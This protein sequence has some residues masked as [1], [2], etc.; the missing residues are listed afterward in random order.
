MIR[1][2]SVE[3]MIS[4]ENAIKNLGVTEE[5][6]VMRAGGAIAEEILSRFKGGRILFVC[7]KGNNGADGKVASA[8][9][10]QKHGFKVGVCEVD[11]NLSAF[12]KEWDV[13]VDCIFGTGLNR[14]VTG[15]PLKVIKAINNA[16]GYKIAVDLPSG[17]GGN[18]GVILGA[19][20]KADLTIAIQEYKLGHFFG[21]GVENSGELV[22]KDIGISVWGDDYA[23]LTE[24]S[25]ALQCFPKR[26]K[27]TS[28]GSYGRA[29]VIGGSKRFCGAPLLA[30]SACLKTGVGYTTLAVPDC[31]F[32]AVAGKN[33]E[34][35]VYTL[36][37][38]N[39]AVKFSEDEI[40]PL[41]TYDSI[42]VGMGLTDTEET[43]KV[44]KYLLEN[45]SGNLILDADGLNSLAVYGKDCL[46]NAKCKVVITPH[47]KEFSR[48]TGLDIK[49][50]LLK[51]V[52]Y[53]KQFAKEYFVTVLL[54]GTVSVITD[55]E[56]TFINTTGCSGMAK[57]GSGDVLSGII[58]GISAR[59]EL[60]LSACAGAYIAGL[61]GEIAQSKFNS[62]CALPTDQIDCIYLAINDILE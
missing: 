55:G 29:C 54:K 27:N 18:G 40:K 6:L 38:E 31:I 42:A 57:G 21:D 44:V 13:I 50:I 26:R 60:L 46:K 28:K 39:G 11:G 49:E 4:A 58:A 10:M 52:H 8:V 53:A 20:V 1:V 61:A 15:N 33:P 17:L 16:K 7:G 14:E 3:E 5:T 19:C 62:Y 41:L 25:D 59:N 37:C 48:L 36:S 47:P 35:I 22:V 12:E 56:R 30:S 45:Y 24:N 2:L 32:N 43:F 34:S 9:L 23:R 51:P